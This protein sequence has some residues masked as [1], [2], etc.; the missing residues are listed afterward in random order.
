MQGTWTGY[1]GHARTDE[2]LFLAD[3]VLFWADEQ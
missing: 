2:M 3:E 1:L